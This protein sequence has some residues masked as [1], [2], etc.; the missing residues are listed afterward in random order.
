MWSSPKALKVNQSP[1]NTVLK[2]S[3]INLFKES[4]GSSVAS[5]DWMWNKGG[6]SY[7]LVICQILNLLVSSSV[8][9]R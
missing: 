1:W 3:P 9:W 8:K 2:P 7:N 6:L 5:L 4:G